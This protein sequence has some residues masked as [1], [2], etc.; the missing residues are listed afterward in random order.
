MQKKLP[1]KAFSCKGNFL[2]LYS[3]SRYLFVLVGVLILAASACSNADGDLEIRGRWQDNYETTHDI[4]N[5]SWFTSSA[6]G[7]ADK[8]IEYYDNDK[9]YL[10]WQRPADDAFNANKFSKVVWIVA[11]RDLATVEKFYYCEI[12][13]G[14]D[15]FAEAEN[16]PDTSDASEPQN[17]GCGGFAWTTMIPK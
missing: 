5:Q 14:K 13:T 15:S 10:I 4:S 16:A 1:K 11:Q 9:R 7:D 6:F 3:L 12:V 17:G 2:S 8:S